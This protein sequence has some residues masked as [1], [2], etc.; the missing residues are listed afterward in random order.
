MQ[1]ILVCVRIGKLGSARESCKASIV[2]LKLLTMKQVTIA[3]PEMWLLLHNIL[4]KLRGARN[5]MKNRNSSNQPEVQ[6]CQ[7]FRG[8]PSHNDKQYPKRV[9][10]WPPTVR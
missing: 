7:Y 8:S 1:H 2:P 4:L 10:L 6:K 5:R 9:V 3:A